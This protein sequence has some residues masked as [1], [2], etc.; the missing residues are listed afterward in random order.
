MSFHHMPNHPND[1]FI[2]KIANHAYELMQGGRDLADALA[3][4]ERDCA[5]A[6]C[7]FHPRAKAAVEAVYDG[8]WEFANAEDN[9]DAQMDADVDAEELTD[10]D[11]VDE[12]EDD[13]EDD[14][15]IADGKEAETEPDVESDATAPSKPK[16]SSKKQPSN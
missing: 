12:D 16:R 11:A 6:N 2:G 4:A 8:T 13:I 10:D 14:Q 9:T 5:R 1:E 3:E 15:D 7:E